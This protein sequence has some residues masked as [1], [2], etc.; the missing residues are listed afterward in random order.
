[1]SWCHHLTWHVDMWLFRIRSYIICDAIC[2][3]RSGSTLAQVM[4]CCLTAPSHYLNQ[5]WPIINGVLWYSPHNNFTVSTWDISKCYVNLKIIILKLQPHFPGANELI[6]SWLVISL[7]NAK[8]GGLITSENH[9]TSRHCG[10]KDQHFFD[11]FE[12]LFFY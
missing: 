9:W 8:A 4:A 12:K 5:C 2:R 11:D 3:H 1:M 10:F 7:Q 6:L